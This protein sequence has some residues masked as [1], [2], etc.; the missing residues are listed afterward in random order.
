MAPGGE[1]GGYGSRMPGE[2]FHFEYSGVLFVA[3]ERLA[4]VRE[5]L[6]SEQAISIRSKSP[7]IP[8]TDLVMKGDLCRHEG[9]LIGRSEG[10]ARFRFD[11]AEIEIGWTE[12]LTATRR[13][14]V[15]LDWIIPYILSDRGQHVL[16]ATAVEIAGAAWG[17][18]GRSG[19]GKSTLAVACAQRGHLLLADD[20]FVLDEEQSTVWPSHPTARLKSDSLRAVTEKASDGSGEKTVIGD[21]D[22][23][24]ADHP[25]GLG[26]VFLLLD[27][28]EF[29]IA[30][31]AASDIPTLLEQTYVLPGHGI[32]AALDG[33]ARLIE[34]GRVHRLCYPRTFDELSSVVDRIVAFAHANKDGSL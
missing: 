8:W 10:E 15:L 28:A 34:R 17:F 33:S 13:T 6:P 32:A 27:D 18:C 11:G 3:D 22:L 1:W 23:A 2:K 16:H 4:G 26:G 14:Q 24:F 25:V 9:A 12:G 19:L 30:P 20:T 31:A 5:A 29:E 21:E 7:S